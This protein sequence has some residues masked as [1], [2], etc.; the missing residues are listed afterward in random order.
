MTNVSPIIPRAHAP[1]PPLAW[2]EA[3]SEATSILG[4]VNSIDAMDFG[5]GLALYDRKKFILKSRTTISDSP[6][7]QRAICTL[8]QEPANYHVTLSGIIDLKNEKVAMLVKFIRLYQPSLSQLLSDE[9]R[10]IL[11][12]L[13]AIQRRILG[14]T[15]KGLLTLCDN[16]ENDNKES[17]ADT[18]RLLAFDTFKEI[19]EM[20]FELAD[21]VHRGVRKIEKDISLIRYDFEGLDLLLRRHENEKDCKNVTYSEKDGV[22]IPYGMIVN[23]NLD[24]IE[25]ITSRGALR[26]AV[27]FIK[28]PEDAEPIPTPFGDTYIPLKPVLNNEEK[29]VFGEGITG[30]CQRDYG[31][32]TEDLCTFYCRLHPS[33][34]LPRF[35]S[36]TIN[37]ELKARE[38]VAGI[39][40]VFSGESFLERKKNFVIHSLNGSWGE[41]E[42]VLGVNEATIYAEK[43]LR[44]EWSDEE[45]LF[46]HV[47]TTLNAT[48]MLPRDESFCFKN[49]NVESLALFAGILINKIRQL[50]DRESFMASLRLGQSEDP[51][52]K[53]MELESKVRVARELASHIRAIKTELLHRKS[54]SASEAQEDLSASSSNISRSGS[55]S[56]SGSEETDEDSYSSSKEGESQDND[57]VMIEN[58]AALDYSNLDLKAL[59][60]A[61]SQRQDRLKITLEG[62]FVTFTLALREIGEIKKQIA[63]QPKIQ[64]QCPSAEF[65]LEHAYHLMDV[66]YQI[67]GKQLNLPN[68]VFSRC[69]EVE[70]FNHFY[71]I[72]DIVVIGICKSGNDRTEIFRAIDSTQILREERLYEEAYPEFVA[73]EFE[74]R[75]EKQLSEQTIKIYYKEEGEL[76]QFEESLKVENEH[77]RLSAYRALFD[78]IRNKDLRCDKL[79]RMLNGIIAREQLEKHILSDLT[80]E[81][82][83]TIESIDLREKLLSSIRTS[84]ETQAEKQAL[85]STNAYLEGYLAD[86][87]YNLI[88]TGVGTGAWGFKLQKGIAANF[89]AY[90]TM[91]LFVTAKYPGG[92][93]ATIRLFN[94]APDG[95]YYRTIG[96]YFQTAMNPT[97]AYSKLILRR[98][99]QRGN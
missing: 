48:T 40:K 1:H 55:I 28:Y 27:N 79:H 23:A 15:T 31:G 24:Q 42:I 11:K 52:P 73:K 78:I 60:N 29:I 92:R 82:P 57:F 76:V 21:K 95:L 65:C 70:M 38:L 22:Q 7:V 14:R 97:N 5:K 34:R 8:K 87:F 25:K 94:Y 91:P 63:G 56:S 61:L 85:V 53:L 30:T 18:L 66:F 81:L 51:F 90:E 86:F 10:Q 19:S 32:G 43:F 64:E 44:Q 58:S 45:I 9:E 88:R 96:K 13:F 62:L 68:F 84:N 89:H 3:I 39:N 16:Y 17:R 74:K 37:T 72:M 2:K 98:S 49:I 6:S 41:K 33:S 47:N 26:N 77:C 93:S 71:K 36:G 99:Q 75:I 4:F 20:T 69:T 67:L 12:I 59:K 35:T 46:A 54:S 50:F 80:D 83:A